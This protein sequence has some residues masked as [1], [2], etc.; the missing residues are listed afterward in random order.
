MERAVA[1]RRR[2]EVLVDRISASGALD[3][4]VLGELAR[5]LTDE[6]LPAARAYEAMLE[7]GWLRD[8]GQEASSC[9][10]QCW[11]SDLTCPA[12]EAFADVEAQLREDG[13]LTCHND[14]DARALDSLACV[15]GQPLAYV[16]LRSANSYRAFGLCRS[17]GHHLEF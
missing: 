5:F 8:G 14:L 7:A 15:C 9:P 17:C 11:K 4:A 6:A 2:L 13:Y 1:A 12:T 10:H 16:G 3:P